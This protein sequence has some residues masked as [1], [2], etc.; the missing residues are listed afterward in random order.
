MLETHEQIAL[1]SPVARLVWRHVATAWS[2]F[3]GGAW[4][5]TAAADGPPNLDAQRA[6]LLGLRPRDDRM[7]SEP[8]ALL[9][10]LTVQALVA[11]RH[12]TW[13]EASVDGGHTDYDVVASAARVY[14]RVRFAYRDALVND[15]LSC[16]LLQRQMRAA[17]LPAASCFGPHSP[18][19][20]WRRVWV[21]PG[22]C[23][24]DDDLDQYLLFEQPPAALTAAGGLAM[25]R[26]CP[27]PDWAPPAALPAATLQIY[28]AVSNDG[29]AFGLTFVRG[30]DVDCDLTAQHVADTAGRV[31]LE[32]GC[33]L[34]RADAHTPTQASLFAAVVALEAIAARDASPIVLRFAYESAR[35]IVARVWAPPLARRLCSVVDARLRAARARCGQQL[36]V[37]GF[38]PDRLQPWG[39][40]ACA[41]AVYGRDHGHW[42]SLPPPLAT[43]T[44][45]A[46]VIPPWWADQ[47]DRECP[48]CFE[49]MTDCW[50]S[51][52]DDA[53]ATAGR[54]HCRHAVCRDCDQRTQHSPNDRCPL[55]RAARRV[56]MFP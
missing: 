28:I 31:P 16:L 18:M 12:A 54:W 20:R 53:R 17:G 55:C 14:E 7:H 4:T 21:D 35:K 8:F 29:T 44:P 33:S 23:T 51:P 24:D 45:V 43:A 2:H 13:L 46:P 32:S 47:A 3:A 26:L 42:G 34:G 30:G 56:R 15:R 22:V 36:W 48:V 10:A 40:R 37:A 39:E 52:S 5:V 11:H 25:Q 1:T 9:R 19:A 6:I 50:P 41:L 27:R 38:R 49:T